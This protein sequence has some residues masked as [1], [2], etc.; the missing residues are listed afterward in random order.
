MKD[1][2]NILC[3]YWVGDFRDRD[4]MENDVVRLRESVERHIDRPYT[5][6]CLTNDVNAV[7]PAE[8]IL[9]EHNWPGWWSKMEI[10]RPDLPQGKTLYMDLDSCVVS[11]LAPIL[12]FPSRRL[13]MFNTLN[14]KKPGEP[15]IGRWVHRY[16]AATMLFTSPDELMSDVYKRFVQCPDEYMECYRSDQ[17]VMGEWIPDQPVFPDEWMVKLG[18]LKKHPLSKDVIIVTGQPKEGSFRDPEFAPWLNKIARGET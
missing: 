10:H 12:D 15:V 6:Y 9:L 14:R 2:V 5:F 1:N 7:I 8:K 3:L 18:S 16:Q 13:T 11:S 4:F 17:D